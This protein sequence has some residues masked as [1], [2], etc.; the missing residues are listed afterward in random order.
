MRAA[1]LAPV[2]AVLVVACATPGSPDPASAVK[3]FE[4]FL[5]QAEA[6]LE[7]RAALLG[8][9][10]PREAAT[11]SVGDAFRMEVVPRNFVRYARLQIYQS[12]PP[13]Y[14]ARMTTIFD[15]SVV[16]IRRADVAKLGAIRLSAPTLVHQRSGNWYGVTEVR[17]H[18]YIAVPTVSEPI[19]VRLV[20]FQ[21]DCLEEVE[22]IVQF[23]KDT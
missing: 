1:V 4:Q 17:H 12:R 15:A 21:G 11:L 13:L 2:A 23:V 9:K 22:H 3:R 8:L 14:L 10:A 6:S 7:E 16:C 19:E 18:E 5:K 20:N